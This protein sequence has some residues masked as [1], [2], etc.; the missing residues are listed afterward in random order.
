M[1]RHL[2]K[3]LRFDSRSVC[4][5]EHPGRAGKGAALFRLDEGARASADV[6]NAKSVFAQ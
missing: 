4:S 6:L 5:P 2:F 3:T 1:P